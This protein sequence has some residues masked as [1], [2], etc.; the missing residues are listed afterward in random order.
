MLPIIM[1]FSPTLGVPQMSTS[2]Q[3]RPL[4]QAKDLRFCLFKAASLRLFLCSSIVFLFAGNALAQAQSQ[5]KSAK[6]AASVEQRPLREPPA[7]TSCAKQQGSLVNMLVL[8]DSIL[9]GQGLKE[10]SK[11]SFQ[12]QN[13]LCEKTHR[14]VRI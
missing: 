1:L 9:W 4:L 10:E 6:V 13:W 5:T 3:S 2:P 7:P 11:I 12:V 14:P 8:G